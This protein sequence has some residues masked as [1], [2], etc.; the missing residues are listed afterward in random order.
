M[1]SNVVIFPLKGTKVEAWFLKALEVSR[2][3]NLHGAR[4]Y[5]T[6]EAPV[7]F[8]EHIMRAVERRIVNGN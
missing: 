3:S 4:T 6:R 5:L 2:I 8:H 1:R 7:Q